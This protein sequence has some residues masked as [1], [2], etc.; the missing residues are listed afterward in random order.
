MK[1]TNLFLKKKSKHLKLTVF[2]AGLLLVS[3]S[4]RVEMDNSILKNAEN[5]RT[6]ESMKAWY[7]AHQPET[8]ILR[9][10][11][12]TEQAQMKPEW[13]RAFKTQNENYEVVET[14]IMRKGRFALHMDSSCAAK[15]IE[16]NDPKYMQCYTRM[17]FRINLD[18]KDTVGFLMTISPNLDWVEK[19][20]FRPFLDMTYLS[21]NKQ[22]GGMILFHNI[23]GSFSNGWRYENGKV[24]GKITALYENP[25]Q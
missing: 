20:N 7:A 6:I 10:S 15:Y 13:S 5:Q 19:S 2:F 8:I 9:S 18:T 17:V 11:D 25:N 3:F 12:G 23:D 4:C 16:T 14:D 21:R 22:F 24:T 1:R